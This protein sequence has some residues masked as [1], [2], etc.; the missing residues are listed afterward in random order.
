MSILLEPDKKIHLKYSNC[1]WCIIFNQSLIFGNL[2]I[3]NAS[4]SGAGK[5]PPM[6]LLEIEEEELWVFLSYYY[7]PFF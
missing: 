1:K 5:L 6:D 7:S 2:K 3:A 4:V